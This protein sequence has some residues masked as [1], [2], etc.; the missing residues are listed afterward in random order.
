MDFYY[1][2]NMIY[3]IYFVVK[4]FYLRGDTDTTPLILLYYYILLTFGID[5]T[6]N[7]GFQII[8]DKIYESTI[9]MANALHQ[10]LESS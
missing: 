4:Y 3:S 7:S 9:L 5:N 6:T 2:K 8:G 10:I 1:Y